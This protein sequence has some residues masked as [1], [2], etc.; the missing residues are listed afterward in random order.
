VQKLVEVKGR[1]W[2]RPHTGDGTA[3][4]DWFGWKEPVLSPCDCT[5]VKVLENKTVNIPGLLGT[6]PAAHLILQRIDGVHFMVAHVQS[7]AV[8]EG[9]RVK[10]GQE[11]AKVGNNGYSRQPHV[12]IGA[13]KGNA[14][15][16]IR[17]DQRFMQGPQLHTGVQ[18]GLPADGSRPAGEP[19]R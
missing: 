5:V 19:R 14:P 13:W 7:V 17:F 16:Q 10:Y 4:E 12:H 1:I 9:Q 3:N 8:R 11:L 18:P 6:P 2:L 15:V